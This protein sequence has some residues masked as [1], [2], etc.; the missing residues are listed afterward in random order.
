MQGKL[1]WNYISPMANVFH[2][3]L[4]SDLDRVQLIGR[5]TCN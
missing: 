4:I 2:L 5:N 3:F 1:N